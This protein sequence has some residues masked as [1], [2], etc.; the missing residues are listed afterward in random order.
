[1]AHVYEAPEQETNRSRSLS[2]SQNNERI[3]FKLAVKGIILK[4]Q[5]KKIK[6]DKI[7]FREPDQ[8]Y[9]NLKFTDPKN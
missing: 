3:D 4:E 6:R 9:E 1:M 7:K 5:P 2:S 8:T